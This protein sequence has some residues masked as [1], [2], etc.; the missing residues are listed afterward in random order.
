MSQHRQYPSLDYPTGWTALLRSLRSIAMTPGS[1]HVRS[2]YEGWFIQFYIKTGYTSPFLCLPNAWSMWLPCCPDR[3]TWGS[4]LC[5]PSGPWA[6]HGISLYSTVYLFLCATVYWD[7]LGVRDWVLCLPSYTWH[8]TNT[9]EEEF[10]Q[11]AAKDT[12]PQS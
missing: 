11:F 1:D 10:L 2:A 3:P 8:T 12:F 4:Q 9:H 5:V 6:C 7:F